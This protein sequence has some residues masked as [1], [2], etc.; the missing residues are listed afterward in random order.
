MRIKVSDLKKM[1]REESSLDIR[2][3]DYGDV[4]SDA[5]EGKRIKSNI[6]QLIKNANSLKDLIND[7]DDLPQW[8]HEKISTA[9]DRVQSV[10]NYLDSKINTDK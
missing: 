5:E 4:A 8:V 9:S 2:N 3:L 6:F 10:F 1:I 7:T